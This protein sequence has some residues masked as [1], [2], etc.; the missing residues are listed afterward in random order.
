MLDF[1]FHNPTKIIF[2]REAIKF[3]AR[4]IPAKSKVMI[5]YGGGNAKHHGL[6]DKVKTVLNGYN[7][8]E[9]SGSAVIFSLFPN[10]TS[11]LAARPI[12]HQC[13]C[14]FLHPSRNI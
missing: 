12:F 6:L 5:T 13:R 1:I 2:G 9:F 3:I 14:I 10:A 8:T 4:E 11:I 7:L